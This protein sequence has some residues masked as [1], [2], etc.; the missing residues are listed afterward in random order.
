MLKFNNINNFS[1]KPMRI[2]F[3]TFLFLIFLSS[4]FPQS[5]Y[6][7]YYHAFSGTTVLTFE[8]GATLG[9][10]NYNGIHPGYLGTASIEYFFPTFTKSSFG[11]RLFGGTGFVGGKDGTKIPELFRT[12]IT[13]GGA[14]F[15]Y[16]LQAGPKV[17]PYFFAGGSYLW[18]DPRSGEDGTRLPNN[19]AGKYPRQEFNFNGEIGSRFLLTDNLSFNLNGGVQVSPHNYFDDI[20]TSPKNDLFFH[21]SAGLSFSFFS[22]RDSDGDGVPDS[23]D[24]CPDTP[25]GV[26]VDEFGCP[27]DSDGDGV[28][29]YLDKCPNTPKNVKVDKDGCPLDSDG[30]GVP[31]YLDICPNTPHGVKVDDLGCPFDM[32]G[33]GVPDY[34]DKCPNTPHNIEVDENGCPKDSDH[35]GV[36]DYLD[37]CP[38]TP[39]GVKVDSN[40]CPIVVEIPKPPEPPKKEEPPIKELVLSAGTY[41][42]LG[43]ADL[44]NAAFPELNKLTKIMKENPV[45]RWLIEGYTDNS[46][47]EKQNRKISLERAQSVLNYFVS[48]GIPRNRFEVSGMGK[49]NPIAS[50]KTEVGRSKNRR[51]VIKKVY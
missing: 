48:K 5:A 3:T 33:D 22:D 27:I 43:K 46:G 30:D 17:F 9:L 20:I 23:K 7:I 41:F 12:T 26:K 15:V 49:A 19:S 18:F 21:I 38:D 14:G 47:S 4:Y 2:L 6:K 31:D 32:D 51:V 13:Y 44:L 42:A 50:N 45:S 28:P 10:T 1:G 36:P 39:A 8:G 29:D 24:K 25:S 37:K 34:L 35:D 40:G 11:L 16:L